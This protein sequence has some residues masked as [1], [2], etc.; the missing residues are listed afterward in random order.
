VQLQLIATHST[1]W[2][3][4]ATRLSVVGS[5]SNM[6]RATVFAF[7]DVA[8]HDGGSGGVVP[9]NTSRVRDNTKSRVDAANA[10]A[11]HTHH[12][13]WATCAHRRVWS[14]RT[15]TCIQQELLCG[16]LRERIGAAL[17]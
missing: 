5:F 4:G 12:A 6:A 7:P 2:G 1:L 9:G 10:N 13:Q 15:R 11:V 8:L 14:P 17:A 16:E 3:S